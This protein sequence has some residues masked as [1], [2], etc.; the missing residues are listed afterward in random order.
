MQYI[1]WKLNP[2][3][4][5]YGCMLT[6]NA[7]SW[8]MSSLKDPCSPHRLLMFVHKPTYAAQLSRKHQ[9]QLPL[10]EKNGSVSQT[11][12]RTAWALG[13]YVTA[14]LI[15]IPCILALWFAE[16]QCKETKCMQD[17]VSRQKQD[18]WV[19]VCGWNF[20]FCRL[21]AITDDH[22]ANL[23]AEVSEPPL[24]LKFFNILCLLSWSEARVSDSSELDTAA[25]HRTPPE[26]EYS[27]SDKDD[28]IWQISSGPWRRAEAN[29]VSWT[30]TIFARQTHL[31]GR[32]TAEESQS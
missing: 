10:S 6:S 7:V 9:K 22:L 21:T 26:D 13:K 14:P 1:K 3:W 24:R 23:V 15:C 20:F 30:M 27:V 29:V 32:R 8:N 2:N 17:N 19:L 25:L 16:S 11:D 31:W 28:S 18:V 12:P 4:E 5:G